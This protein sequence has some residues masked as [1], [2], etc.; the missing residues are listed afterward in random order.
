[1]EVYPNE[2]TRDLEQILGYSCSTIARHLN[3][4]G[5]RKNVSLRERRS[6]GRICNKMG[7]FTHLANS[8]AGEDPHM[9]VVA[10]G[11]KN[12]V[13]SVGGQTKLGYKFPLHIP[14]EWDGAGIACG[15]NI[16]W[17]DRVNTFAGDQYSFSSTEILPNSTLAE[18]RA[19]EHESYL[20]INSTGSGYVVDELYAMQFTFSFLSIA[21]WTAGVITYAMLGL[22]RCIAICYYGTKLKALNQVSVAIVL[23]LCTW[24]I[25][26]VAAFLGTI[27]KPLVG[28]RRDMWTVSFL[29]TRGKRPVLSISIRVI[30]QRLKICGELSNRLSQMPEYG[31]SAIARYLNEMGYRKAMALWTP[32]ALSNYDR[33]ARM[34]ICECIMQRPAQAGLSFFVTKVCRLDQNT[35]CWGIQGHVALRTSSTTNRQ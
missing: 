14:C 18:L 8:V 31:R 1:M 34:I 13:S 33:A 28:V 4:M 24:I 25:G 3:E 7:G 22:N 21:A 2:S 9:C 15:W 20:F 11:A 12:W 17:S 30:A 29:T 5:C 6:Y 27:P 26:I 23:S 35:R 32:R 16:L 19:D 10:S